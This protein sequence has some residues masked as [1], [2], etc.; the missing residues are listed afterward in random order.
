M[1]LRPPKGKPPA[2]P[3]LSTIYMHVLAFFDQ[4]LKH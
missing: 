3:D 1:D 4:H 2:E